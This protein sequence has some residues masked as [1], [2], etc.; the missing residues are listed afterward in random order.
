MRGYPKF[1]VSHP[2][3]NGGIKSYH[4]LTPY[5]DK[6]TATA[7][8]YAKQAAYPEGLLLRQLNRDQTRKTINP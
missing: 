5:T 4:R 1:Y 6:A 2:V 7:T 8:F 3:N